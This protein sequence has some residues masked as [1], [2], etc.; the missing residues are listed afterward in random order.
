MKILWICV[1]VDYCRGIREEKKDKWLLT[2]L[3]KEISLGTGGEETVFL[4]E[5][6]FTFPGELG[7]SPG[8]PANL[9]QWYPASLQSFDLPFHDFNG[10]DTWKV[11]Y[12]VEP[13]DEVAIQNLET[14]KEKKFVDVNKEDLELGDTDE[15]NERENQ[16]ELMRAQTLGDTSTLEFMRE[17]RIMEVNPD[18]PIIKDLNIKSYYGISRNLL[19]KFKDDTIDETPILKCLVQRLWWI[20]DSR[21]WADPDAWLFAIQEYFTLFN[22]PVEQCPY[23]LWVV[24]L[25]GATIEYFGLMSRNEADYRLGNG[26]VENSPG[27]VFGPF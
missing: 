5:R 1:L 25:E 24:N 6:I 13:I 16:Q 20:E 27:C 15:A 19:V 9:N 4:F 26:F 10:L 23:G 18:H 7:T 2:K 3:S 8:V 21:I 14:Y 11:L 22:T 12:L 17:R